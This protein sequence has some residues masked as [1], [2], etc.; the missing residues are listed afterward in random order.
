MS[1]Q[2]EM[3]Q[4]LVLEVELMKAK[5]P[6]GELK[7]IQ[8]SLTDIEKGQSGLKDDIRVIQKRLFNPDNGIIVGVNKNTEFREE[9]EDQIP[10]YDKKVSEFN[11][12]LSWKKN[13]QKALWLIYSA[14]IGLVIKLLFFD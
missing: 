10:L 6:N 14:I 3:L 1:T 7:L 4:Q 5:L 8:K 12:V 9:R 11:A 13:I 2:K